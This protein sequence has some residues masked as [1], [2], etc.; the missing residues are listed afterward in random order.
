MIPD[1]S[2]RGSFDVI[3]LG[4]LVVDIPIKVPQKSIDF[5]AD[6]IK[7]I[8]EGIRT[9]G[10]AANSAVVLVKLGRKVCLASNV[11]DDYLGKI[12]LLAMDSFGVDISHV[13]TSN[14]TAT[15]ISFVLINECAQRTF[16]CTEGSKELLGE[17]DFD[18]E[19][20]DCARHINFSSLFL[21]PILDKGGAKHIFM[22][23][24]EKGLTTSADASFDARGTGFEGI[25]DFLEYVDVF[26][27][28]YIEGNYLTGERAPEKMADFLIN[29]TGEKIIV[30]KLGGDGCFVRGKNESFYQPAFPTKV[31]D[32]TGA[33][34]S[35]FSWFS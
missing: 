19:L 26:M 28:S 34:D 18:Y 20:L 30:I 17:D 13:K 14:G 6:T 9:G 27:P 25:K 33:G 1:T 4:C 31:V 8:S 21:N 2:K 35:F 15:T 23:A 16:L 7:V 22:R 5:N 32:T 29:K 24:K 12:V 10:D 11:G 3:D